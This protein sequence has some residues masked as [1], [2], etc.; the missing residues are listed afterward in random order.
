MVSGAALSSWTLAGFVAG[1]TL[2]AI[3]PNWFESGTT[4]TVDGRN[5]LVLRKGERVEVW[6]ADWGRFR[7][8]ATG[9]RSIVLSDPEEGVDTYWS[10]DVG[11][12]GGVLAVRK[13]DRD[14]DL[15][16]TV[17]GEQPLELGRGHGVSS[18]ETRDADGLDE[19][20]G[21]LDGE[22]PHLLLMPTFS[23]PGQDFDDETAASALDMLF[24]AVPEKDRAE[25]FRHLSGFDMLEGGRGAVDETTAPSQAQR[26]A[27]AWKNDGIPSDALI[28][29]GSDPDSVATG[30]S[31][32][33]ALK[34][35]MPNGAFN[36]VSLADGG[37]DP[38]A[39]V[40][41]SAELALGQ[42][43]GSYVLVFPKG[44]YANHI[45]SVFGFRSPWDA[46]MP[47]LG[48][49]PKGQYDGVTR[50]PVKSGQALHLD[51]NN[52]TAR[53]IPTPSPFEPQG[54]PRV[55]H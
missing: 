31:L 45:L 28:M 12:N 16:W 49:L 44:R 17:A 43:R 26:L 18:D 10:K 15:L 40:R 38:G 13:A 42:P 55:V 50:H 53:I 19:D 23:Y 36:T 8:L 22:R 52:G 29:T 32:Q 14:G 54:G 33:K 30:Y 35:E 11:P 7:L 9:D 1:Y 51:P 37:L 2:P 21:D 48:S 24:K 47:G 27:K 34:A 6:E 4:A 3:A 39:Y 41:E 46:V 25:V 20:D 5:V